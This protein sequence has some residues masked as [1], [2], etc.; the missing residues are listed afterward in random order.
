[1]SCSVAK[2]GLR[3][4]IHFNLAFIWIYKFHF[5]TFIPCECICTTWILHNMF[6]LLRTIYLRRN[7]TNNNLFTRKTC[8]FTERFMLRAKFRTVLWYE[9][10]VL[11]CKQ[12]LPSRI[13]E[14]FPGALSGQ[15]SDPNHIFKLLNPSLLSRGTRWRCSQHCSKQCSSL[16]S[17]R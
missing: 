11:I 9:I 14:T 6:I 12:L 2:K 1:M 10:F 17:W 4:G 15:N 8:S 3:K 16:A 5:F 13:Y 7:T